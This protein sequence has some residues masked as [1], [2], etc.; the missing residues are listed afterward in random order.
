MSK[1][2][3]IQVYITQLHKPGTDSADDASPC[4]TS[5]EWCWPYLALWVCLST[6]VWKMCSGSLQSWIPTFSLAGE[7][8]HGSISQNQYYGDHFSSVWACRLIFSRNA[9]SPN[10]IPVHSGSQ[11]YNRDEQRPLVATYCHVKR[12]MRIND[13]KAEKQ[14]LQPTTVVLGKM[15][16][17]RVKAYEDSPSGTIQ[18]S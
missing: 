2:T 10:H 4:H 16:T 1:S 18:S 17:I 3:W 14:N 12:A 8:K 7:P 11:K 6:P 5:D 15:D 9:F 13:F